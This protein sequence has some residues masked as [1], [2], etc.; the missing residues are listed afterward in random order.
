MGEK[1]HTKAQADGLTIQPL[2]ETELDTA[3]HLCAVCVGE[4]L[5]PKEE[6]KKILTDPDQYFYFLMTPER[7]AAGYIYFYLTDLSRMSTLSKLP[8]EQL[9]LISPKKQPL[10]G[11]LQSI[12]IV[13]EWRGH[14]LADRLVQLFLDMLQN[15]LYADVAFGVFWKPN[16]YVPMEKPLKRQ[17]FLCLGES[18]RVWYDYEHLICPYCN[19][20]CECNA[21]I[22][23]KII[24][25]EEVK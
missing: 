25:E 9:A 8:L 22:F 19:G 6:L 18:K 17:G 13:E 1:K 23:Y 15:K 3:V 21:E 20:R 12:A 2:T 5:Y 11:N 16:G 4:N 24:G 14:H 7:E 10:I